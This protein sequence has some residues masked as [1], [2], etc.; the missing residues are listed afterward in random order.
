[1]V[2]QT[3]KAALEAEKRLAA[4]REANSP[5]KV[6]AAR[7]KADAAERASQVKGTSEQKKLVNLINERADLEEKLRKTGKA[8]TEYQ[9]IRAKIAE[10][11]KATAE[12]T[13]DFDKE[14]TEQAEKKNKAKKELVEKFAPTVEQLAKQ[15]TGG[16]VEGNDPRLKARQALKEEDRART[17]FER[18]DYKGGLAA[19]QK[20]QGLRKGLEMQTSDT[21]VLTPKAAEEAFSDALKDTNAKLDDLTKAVAGVI[22]AQK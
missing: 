2:V 7:E 15:E 6:A 10:N 12:A 8:T 5:E 9:E 19:A 20:A 21:G 11:E 1:M 13:V 4:S 3:E 18:G 17:L 22:R 16:F 14:A